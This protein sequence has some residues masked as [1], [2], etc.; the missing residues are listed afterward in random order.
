M[1]DQV[2]GHQVTG[3]KA[4]SSGIQVMRCLGDK[5]TAVSY[6]LL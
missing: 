3:K 1:G 5:A 4:R 6:E 2:S